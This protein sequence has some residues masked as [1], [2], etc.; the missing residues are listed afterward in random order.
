MGATIDQPLD[1]LMIEQETAARQTLVDG[2][3][4]AGHRIAPFADLAEFLNNGTPA[5]FDLAF[6]P[7]DAGSGRSTLAKLHQRC[8][9]ARIVL[10]VT[11]P[12]TPDINHGGREVVGCVRKPVPVE[13]AQQLARCVAELRDM[14]E[15]LAD[16]RGSICL[17]VPIPIIQPLNTRVRRVMTHARQLAGEPAPL[18]LRGEF[19]VGKRLLASLIH[20]WGPYPQ[21]PCLFVRA[22]SAD[23]PSS[24][25][26]A[27]ERLRRT[28]SRGTLVFEEIGE[29]TLGQQGEILALI[30]AKDAGDDPDATLPA[31]VKIVATTSNDLSVAAKK[32]EFCEELLSLLMDDTL[33]LPP[34]R[35]RPEDIASLAEHMLAHFGYIH[36]RPGLS[37][38][39]EAKLA[40][41]R[42]AWPGNTHE[43]RN[44]IE[45]VAL[46]AKKSEIEESEFHLRTVT[47][48]GRHRSGS[49]LSLDAMEKQHIQRVMRASSTLEE[50]ARIL[51]VDITTL[52]RKRH[53]YGI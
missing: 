50:A 5:V 48:S 18:L 42:C 32:G 1:I 40:L 44:V 16:L 34:L 4:S 13:V 20:Q 7:W 38:E 45:R 31:G 27:V 25:R 10:T 26:E 29:F 35:E 49:Y 24:A 53:R 22:A 19:G 47:E 11:D 33:C 39:P 3:Q 51:H 2:L 46:T 9:R 17:A 30:V 23:S 36:H 41:L 52:W 37:L 14:E 21:S 12:V 15:E 8:P 28:G 43:L 6:I